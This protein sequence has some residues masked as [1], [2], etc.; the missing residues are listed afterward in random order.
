MFRLGVGRETVAY[1]EPCKSASNRDPSQF[2]YRALISLNEFVRSGVPIGAALD[3]GKRPFSSII[4]MSWPRYGVG[5]ICV[6]IHT[7]GRQR[8]CI[9]REE[10]QDGQ[11]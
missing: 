7:L 11:E 3:P 6:P 5:P 10:Q 9:G 1:S 8:E 4:S 2:S